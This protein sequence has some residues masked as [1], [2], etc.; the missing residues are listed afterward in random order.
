MFCLLSCFLRFKLGLS[1][2][3]R[4]GLRGRQRTRWVICCY[5]VFFFQAGFCLGGSVEHHSKKLISPLQLA[6]PLLLGFDGD[7]QMFTMN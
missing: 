1:P 4:A 2:G 6:M 3:V 7:S 5:S